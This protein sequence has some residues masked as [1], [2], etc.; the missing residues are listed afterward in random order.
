MMWMVLLFRILRVM[1]GDGVVVE[2]D[3]SNNGDDE[4]DGGEDFEKKE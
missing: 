2:K 3:E 4:D 1:R